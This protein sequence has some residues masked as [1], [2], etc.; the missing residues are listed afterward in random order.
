MDKFIFTFDFVKK[1]LL[2]IAEVFLLVFGVFF[3]LAFF[4]LLAYLKQVGASSE[5]RLI[6]GWELI[7]LAN[8]SWACVASSKW[9]HWK[10][11]HQKVLQDLHDLQK[12]YET[13]RDS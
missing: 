7:S 8:W 4:L 13:I 6:F 1:R 3:L 12:T 11:K 9:I 10:L 5:E 2:V